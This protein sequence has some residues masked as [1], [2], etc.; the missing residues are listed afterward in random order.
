MTKALAKAPSPQSTALAP[1]SLS[2][3]NAFANYCIN[4]R[5]TIVSELTRENPEMSSWTRDE[6]E[7]MTNRFKKAYKNRFYKRGK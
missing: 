1:L 2:P 3:A 6:I 5:H 4:Y 7:D